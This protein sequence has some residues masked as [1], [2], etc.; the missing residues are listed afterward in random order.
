VNVLIVNL[1]KLASNATDAKNVT[2]V[3]NV[4]TA[5]LVRIANR[6]Q[7]VN[8]ARNASHVVIVHNLHLK[9]D[10]NR[11]RSNRSSP[12]RAQYNLNRVR[13][14]LNRVQSSH[15]LARSS[16]ANLKKAVHNRKTA[17][18]HVHKLAAVE[19][20]IATVSRTPN[21]QGAADAQEIVG[22]INALPI[23]QL[24]P[25]RSVSLLHDLNVAV[26]VANVNQND[27]LTKHNLSQN[28]LVADNRCERSTPNIG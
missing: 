27:R 16:R 3:L 21:S 11:A 22:Q 4:Q 1:A 5:D 9:F 7:I 2:N 12:N 19:V 24:N 10:L 25:S 14:N 6:A 23:S 18:V 26:V 13:Y 8:R 17:E 15:N 20:A 28:Q